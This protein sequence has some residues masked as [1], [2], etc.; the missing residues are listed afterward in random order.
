M[1]LVMDPLVAKLKNIEIVYIDGPLNAKNGKQIKIRAGFIEKPADVPFMGSF[2]I[3]PGRSEY[4]EKYAETIIELTN[5]GYN[6]L[7]IDPR[8]QGLSDRIGD[9]YWYGDI[10]NYDNS[11]L[12]L[13]EAI[14]Y[15]DKKLVGKR[16]VISHSMGG[17]LVL[18]GIINE[19]LGRIDGAI[20]NTPMWSFPPNIVIRSLIYSLCALGFKGNTTPSF[21]VKWRPGDYFTNK[22]TSDKKRYARNN[23]LMLKEPRLQIGGPTNGWF[24][25]A[26]RTFRKFSDENLNKVNLPILILQA[27]RET[28]VD[29][30]GQT[31]I[32]KKLP[33]AI[34]RV[35]DEG[36]HELLVESDEIRAEIWYEIDQFLNKH[37]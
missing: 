34:L 26:F 14:K 30:I 2:I 15:F 19:V 35:F 11:S 5:R 10:D 3:V 33:N 32:S 17:M 6:C 16:F 18:N 12:H 13:A 31:Q 20:F 1:D 27:G 29:N 4:I 9:E 25:E 37:K 8:G 24:F 22:V 28:L 36:K 21:E 23:S 7:C